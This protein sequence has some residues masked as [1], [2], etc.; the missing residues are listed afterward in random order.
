MNENEC[1][2]IKVC[3]TVDELHSLKEKKYYYY[4]QTDSFIC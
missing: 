4:F 2:A 3:E 1:K